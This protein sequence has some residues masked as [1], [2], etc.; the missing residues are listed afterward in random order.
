MSSGRAATLYTGEILALAVELARYPFDDHAP[1]RGS[2]RSQSCGSTLDMSLSC[3]PHGRVSAVGMRVTA[4]AI[5][6]ASAAIFARHAAGCDFTEIK[7]TRQDI[8]AW[9]AGTGSLPGWPDFAVIAPAQAYPGRHGA[10]L[11]PWKA[12]EQALSKA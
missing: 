1:L 9:L 5:G 3:D 2:S 6:Q 11:L 10:I 7:G 12:A 8:E 4:C